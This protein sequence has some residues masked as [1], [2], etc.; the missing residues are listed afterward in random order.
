MGASA[1]SN[2]LGEGF[3]TESTT[4][5]R[6][7]ALPRINFNPI[8]SAK[9]CSGGR[10]KSAFSVGSPELALKCTLKLLEKN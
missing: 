3:A 8:C 4:T 9:A 5:V 2:Q 6:T 10:P 1:T 7:G